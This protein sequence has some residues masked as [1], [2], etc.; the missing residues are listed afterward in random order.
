MNHFFFSDG[1]QSMSKS[2]RGHDSRKIVPAVLVKRKADGCEVLIS[3]SKFHEALHEVAIAP[4]TAR[5]MTVTTPTGTSSVEINHEILER[6]PLEGLR[7]LEIARYVPGGNA[8]DK[9]NLIKGILIILGH[10]E[11]ASNKDSLLEKERELLEAYEA[12][13]AVEAEAEK[14]AP[15]KKAPAKKAPAKKEE[16]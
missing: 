4:D 7:G 5:V 13:K 11:A 12:E 14:K 1:S 8:M 9:R 6:M 3:E 2:A 15:A 10:T 16:V